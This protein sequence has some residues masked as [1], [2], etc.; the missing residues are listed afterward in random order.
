MLSSSIHMYPKPVGLTGAPMGVDLLPMGDA[1]DILEQ[2]LFLEDV[3]SGLVVEQDQPRVKAG[4][5]RGKCPRFKGLA[6]MA[7]R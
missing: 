1:V 5:S 6:C 4:G 3:D 7:W 2:G